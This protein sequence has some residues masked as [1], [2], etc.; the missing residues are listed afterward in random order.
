MGAAIVLGVVFVFLVVILAG[1]LRGLDWDDLR[2]DPSGPL[3]VAG[4]RGIV[5]G[6]FLV[7]LAYGLLVG[8]QSGAETWR[9]LSRG[10]VDGLVVACAGAFYIGF[11]QRKRARAGV[12]RAALDSE[13]AES[14]A[15]GSSRADP[16]G[17]ESVEDSSTGTEGGGRIT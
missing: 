7:G 6:G 10:V 12:Q 15:E 9:W 2:S 3:S 8:G 4:V 5:G 13:S 16:V 1:L 14:A 17:A 11:Q